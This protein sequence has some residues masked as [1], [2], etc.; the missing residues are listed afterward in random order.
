MFVCSLSFVKPTLFNSDPFFRKHYVT[1]V[2]ETNNNLKMSSDI[3]KPVRIGGHKLSEEEE[4]TW[5]DWK[6]N[7]GLKRVLPLTAL[8]GI[9]TL[10]LVKKGHL[11]ESAKFGALPKAF[12]V[13]CASGASGT[14]MA[15]N[16]LVESFVLKHPNSKV[17]WLLRTKLSQR[18]GFILTNEETLLSIAC[19]RD[20]F[21]SKGL[22]GS[23]ILSAAVNALMQKGLLSK[24]VKFGI[25]PKTISAA[26]IGYYIGTT[27]HRTTTME[28][29]L[30]EL[31][32]SNMSRDYRKAFGIKITDEEILIYSACLHNAIYFRAVPLSAL[33]GGIVLMGMQKGR[34]KMSSKYGIWPKVA[35]ALLAGFSLGIIINSY[36]CGEQFLNELPDSQ[37]SK[38]LLSDAAK[39]D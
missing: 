15:V 16:D 38:K 7:T 30:K 28:R 10:I 5:K 14:M 39:H 4:E 31:P 20:A 13:A 29:F 24:S 22:P 34:I 25:W 9:A 35:P 8:G 33:L 37:T 19:K 21:W 32:G 3:R 1:K 26:I 12:A 6:W 23:L 18:R 11:K 27:L 2:L 17:T 36:S